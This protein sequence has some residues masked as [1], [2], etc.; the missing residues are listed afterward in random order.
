MKGDMVSRPV[1]GGLLVCCGDANIVL[2]A[3]QLKGL[4]DSWKRAKVNFC[5]A[6]RAYALLMN[7]LPLPYELVVW[8]C[9]SCFEP[10]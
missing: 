7:L 1:L 9:N 4:R 6:R 8:V 3:K 10:V 5:C 2:S